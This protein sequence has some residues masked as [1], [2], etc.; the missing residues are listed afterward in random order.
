M[1]DDGLKLL[2]KYANVIRDLPS[3]ELTEDTRRSL[4]VA[5]EPPIQIVYAPFDWINAQARVVICGITPGRQSMM[6]A[7]TAA[8]DALR[9]GLALDEVSRRAK[10]TGI[11]SNMRRTI[12]SML[13]DLGLNDILGIETSIELFGNDGKHRNLVHLT[14]C[15][16]YP[17]FAELRN[18]SGH[19]PDILKSTVLT[20]FIDNVLG[21]ELAQVPDAVIVPC[22][23]AVGGV[24]RYLAAKGIIDEGRCLFA[25]PHASGANGHRLKFFQERKSELATRLAAWSCKARCTST[26]AA[27]PATQ[28]SICAVSSHLSNVARTQRI[29]STDL[30]N[31]QIRLPREAKA[32]FP[33]T[34]TRLPITLRRNTLDARYDPRIGPDRERSAVLYMN[35]SCLSSIA[36]GEV[37]QVSRDSSGSIFLD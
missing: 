12:G 11:F 1:I 23:E 29:T 3:G 16:R 24:L 21:P 34:R 26:T 28:N 7:L 15:I 5:D 8:R 6:N 19:N 27:A 18:Y 36:D 33:S 32:L 9:M 31:G 20:R 35:K 13:D 22:G 2:S 14:S 30:A 4:L 10:Q 37:L 25:F 17:A